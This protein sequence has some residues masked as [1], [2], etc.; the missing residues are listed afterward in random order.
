MHNS[1]YVNMEI[2]ADK[3]LNPSSELQIFDLGSQDVHPEET[4]NSYRPIFSKNSKWK[5]VGG[6]MVGGKNVD[7]VL[8][9]IYKWDE[10]KSSSYDVVISGQAFEHIEFFWAT[11]SEIE[12][13]LKPNGYCCIIAP[14]SGIL[15]RYPL[16]CWRYYEDGFH[17]LARFARLDVAEIYTQR[18]KFK[19]PNYD[20]VWQDTVFIAKKPV[21]SL[22]GRIKE[23]VRQN[24]NQR[25]VSSIPSRITDDNVSTHAQ[26]FY[27]SND[28][29]FSE[30]KSVSEYIDIENGLN[31]F[32]LDLSQVSNDD[33]SSLR[34]DPGNVP[35]KFI[36]NDAVMYLKDGK[37]IHLKIESTNATEHNINEYIFAHYDPQFVFNF[38]N[39]HLKSIENCM[40]SGYI[41]IL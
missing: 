33:I 3:Y 16:D 34:F 23:K 13:V 27:K 36:F 14:S 17:A 12:R 4:D 15:H 18:S 5:Y 39:I 32:Y 20:P 21:R 35:L 8:K 24:I 11:M 2:F 40:I 19:Y 1:S 6:D 38:P 22:S 25:L 26:F 10:L 30:E 41:K 7:V 9:N 31:N 29:Q 28:E 37:Q